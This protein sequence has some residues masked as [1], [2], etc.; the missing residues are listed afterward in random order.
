MNLLKFAY[1]STSLR[2]IFLL[3]NGTLCHQTISATHPDIVMVEL[4][5]GR[6]NILHMDEELILKEAQDMSLAKIRQAIRQV[7][8]PTSMGVRATN[9]RA[10]R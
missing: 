8:M 6:M 2:L 10:V 7:R 3:T 5:K 1:L 9:N 4:C